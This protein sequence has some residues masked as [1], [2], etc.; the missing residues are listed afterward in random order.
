LRTQQPISRPAL[1]DYL[2]TFLWGGISGLRIPD[3]VPKEWVHGE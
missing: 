3:G 1:S 2:T